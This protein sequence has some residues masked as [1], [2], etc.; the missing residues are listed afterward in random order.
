MCDKNSVALDKTALRNAVRK[1]LIQS[2]SELSWSVDHSL[3]IIS[4][5][6]ILRNGTRVT[7]TSSTSFYC[8]FLLLLLLL[9]V[10]CLLFVWFGLVFVLL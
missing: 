10:C 6:R 8:S 9:L 5:K 7:L 1:L 3:G 2:R 4:F